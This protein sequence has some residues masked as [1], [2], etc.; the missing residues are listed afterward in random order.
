[1]KTHNLDMKGGMK[2]EKMEEDDF[3]EMEEE[4]EDEEMEEELP[5]PK[6]SPANRMVP[7]KPVQVVKKPLAKQVPKVQ[8]KV[9]ERY[10]AYYQPEVFAVI[11]NVSGEI[12]TD[13]LPS[14][15]I[16]KIEAYKLNM[17][18]KIGIVSGV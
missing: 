5:I 4:L 2:Q 8:E 7:K 15:G 16:A 6:P 18:D 3:E 10:Q 12:V 1:M 9:T 11:D 17:L 14:I 13:G